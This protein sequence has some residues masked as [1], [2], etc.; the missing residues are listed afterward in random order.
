M[1]PWF[2]LPRRRTGAAW[3][4]ILFALCLSL[5]AAPVVSA[6]G[7]TYYVA[8]SGAD[9]N[10]GLTLATPF[11]TIQKCASVAT[12]GDTCLIRGGTYR[13]TVTVPRSGSAGNPITFKAYNAETVT[14]SGADVLTA[15]WTQHSGRI[16]RT[17]LPWNLDIRDANQVTDNQ[18]FLDGQ[19]LPAARWPNISPEDVTHLQNSHKARADGATRLNASAAIY[20]DADLASFAAGA[21]TGARISFGPGWGIINT[22]CD[23]TDSTAAS[24]SFQCNPDPGAD[25]QRAEWG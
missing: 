2:M 6:T 7:A 25:N 9:S 19:M 12:A 13:E 22:T 21:W 10:D 24:V 20:Q 16:Y 15:A 17:T 18:I 11:A 1:H 5:F 4:L 23:V 8:P 3:F 14:L